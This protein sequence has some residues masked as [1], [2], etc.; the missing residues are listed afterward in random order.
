MALS[1]GMAILVIPLTP[2]V[3]KRLL[4]MEAVSVLR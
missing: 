3:R 4:R 2:C 1:E